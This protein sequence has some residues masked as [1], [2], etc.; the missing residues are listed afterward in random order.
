MLFNT[1]E[2]IFFFIATVVMYYILQ[3]KYRWM[4]L[5]LVSYYFYYSWEPKLTI[6]LMTSTLVDYFC[7]IKIYNSK[8]ITMRKLYLIISIGVNL[9]LLIFFKYLGFFTENT[10][11]I[12][13]FFGIEV[14][15]VEKTKSTYN[16]TRILLPIGISFYTFQTL[17]YSI[18]I[19]RGNLKPERHLGRYAL[20]VSFFPQLVAG[21]IERARTL[22]PQLRNKIALNVESIR[23]GLMLMAWGFFMKM[24]VADRLGVYVDTVFS[25]PWEFA[26]IPLIIGAYFFACQIYFDFAAY[27][28]IAIGAARILGLNLMANFNRPVFVKDASEFWG[29]WHISFMTWLRDYLYRPLVKRGGIKKTLG[30]INRF[31]GLWFLAWS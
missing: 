6:L 8:K 10:I 21:P 15:D 25:K 28:I 11:E 12:I 5:L 3:H 27:S 4:W 24:V 9:A 29:C 1:F 23:I 18:D 30:L 14:G 17:S 2:F 7:G 13:K 19:Y 31:C 20:F 26:G 22:V 16:L